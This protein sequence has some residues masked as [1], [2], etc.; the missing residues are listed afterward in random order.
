LRPTYGE[1]AYFIE[2][3]GNSY[4]ILSYSY[5]GE[6]SISLI[7]VKM[8]LFQIYYTTIDRGNEGDRKI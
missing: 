1:E 4:I 3:T 7:S 6:F 5:I 2:G 8:S